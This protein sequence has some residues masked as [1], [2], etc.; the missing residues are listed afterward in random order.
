VAA[1]G[2]TS[3]PE[4]AGPTISA[5][6]LTLNE[7][8]NIERCL[9]SLSWADE[10]VVVDSGSQDSTVALAED[11]GARIV[12]HRP[13]GPFRI[14][15]QRNWALE[16]GRL[17][18]DWVLFLDA[19]EEV[20]ERLA[21]EIR[22]T[23][24]SPA[25]PDAFQLA[26]KYLFLDRWMRRSMRYPAWHDRL[27]RRGKV[28]YTGGVWEHFTPETAVGRIDE[29]YVH[30]GNSKGFADWLR[31]HDRYSTWD[32]EAVVAYLDSGEEGSFRT[33]LR[34]RHRMVAARL[35]RL[36]PLLRFFLMYIWRGGFLEGPAAL[37]LCL[38][39]AIYDY[40]TVEKVIELRRKRSG[41]P[42]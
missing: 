36:R 33:S 35:W 21:T 16:H 18:G 31:R 32:A 29:S 38:R 23:C 10:V 2:S 12:E 4:S 40:M 9:R 24:G 30:Y 5:V 25:A 15:D 7:E 42:L 28:S 20:P 3:N 19:D 41:E 11:A 14:A 27:L 17:T 1:E 13:N 37:M 34:L 22:Q 8:L 6:V 39:Y 26:P